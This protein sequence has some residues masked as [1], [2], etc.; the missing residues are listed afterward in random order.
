MRREPICSISSREADEPLIGTAPFAPAWICLE[1]PGAWGAQALT[2]SGLDATVGAAF[3]NRATNRAIRPSLI[4][5]PGRHPNLHNERPWVFVA[6]TH[7]E[8][9]W[10]YAGQ[11]DDPLDILTLDLDPV[12]EGVPDLPPY[13]EEVDHEVLFVCTNGRR[14]ACCA[15]LGRPALAAAAEAYPGRVWEITHLSGHRFAPTSV[16]LP[17]GH[18]HGRMDDPSAALA[19]SDTGALL[20]DGWRGRSTWK[21]EAQAAEQA[22]RDVNPTLGLNALTVAEGSPAPDALGFIVSSAAESWSVEVMTESRGECAP[23]CGKEPVPIARY[24]TR[25]A[26]RS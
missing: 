24:T 16:L 18:L 25:V 14:D 6:W 15:T 5:R 7:P 12:T 23:S 21:P 11:L 4:R 2:D 20:L 13:F 22:V 8:R 17:S 9:P 19:A 3:E 10:L 26:S 1:Q